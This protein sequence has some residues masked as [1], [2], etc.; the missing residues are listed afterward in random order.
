M[1][2]FSLRLLTKAARELPPAPL[3][4]CL[5]FQPEKVELAYATVVLQAQFQRSDNY[6]P[7]QPLLCLC[8]VRA[9][10]TQNK[11]A[12][13]AWLEGGISPKTGPCTA[14]LRCRSLAAGSSLRLD[15][16]KLPCP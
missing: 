13:S 6:S 4:T 16:S 15:E 12:F 7:G 14:A 11:S 1:G 9:G 10:D 8:F 5:P 3:G 2:D